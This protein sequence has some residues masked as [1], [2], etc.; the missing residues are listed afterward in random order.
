MAP[1]D[2]LLLASFSQ[3]LTT[4]LALTATLIITLVAWY[5]RGLWRKVLTGH[6]VIDQRNWKVYTQFLMKASGAI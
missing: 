2:N 4:H 5:V 6:I 3:P 1:D